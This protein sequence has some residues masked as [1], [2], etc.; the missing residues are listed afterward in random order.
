M[1]VR[2]YVISF[3]APTLLVRCS[4][5]CK[6]SHLQWPNVLL[7]KT[8]TDAAKPPVGLYNLIKAGYTITKIRYFIQCLLAL[9]GLLHD[10]MKM[11]TL[12]SL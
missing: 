11:S 3:I 10:I 5:R 2:K 8:Y 4:E 7:W 1:T 9:L 6:I 12:T